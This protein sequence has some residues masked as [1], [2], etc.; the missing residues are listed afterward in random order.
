MTA[1][2]QT[3]AIWLILYLGCVLEGLALAALLLPVPGAFA[4]LVVTMFGILVVLGVVL[5]GIAV[6]RL[7]ALVTTTAATWQWV[8]LTTLVLVGMAAWFL[9]RIFRP[10]T[11]EQLAL[12]LFVLGI[13]AVLSV[14]LCLAMNTLVKIVA[15]NRRR[16]TPPS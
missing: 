8:L 11:S 6:W 15:G 3:P 16:L 10:D 12:V 14:L 7:S 5:I 1:Q 13:G 9:G 2:K 4:G